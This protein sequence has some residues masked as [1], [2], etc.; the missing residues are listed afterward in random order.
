MYA[1][2]FFV[3][4]VRGNFFAP[5]IA[6]NSGLRTFGAKMPFVAFVTVVFVVVATVVFVVVVIAIGGWKCAHA[7]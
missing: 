5:Q 1:Q 7:S 4:S 6:A 3:T 2:I